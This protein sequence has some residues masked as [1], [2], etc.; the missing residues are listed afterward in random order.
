MLMVHHRST[1]R[2]YQL[3]AYH[4]ISLDIHKYVFKACGP[5]VSFF[6][7]FKAIYVFNS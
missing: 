4:I 7:K 3:A 1:Y 2:L 6:D 5:K